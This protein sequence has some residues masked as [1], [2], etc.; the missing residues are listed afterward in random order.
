MIWKYFKKLTEYI[1]ILATMML[2]HLL[3]FFYNCFNFRSDLHGL[4]EIWER[5]FNLQM[6]VVSSNVLLCK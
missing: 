6:L 4:F 2:F 5:T 3:F 1:K